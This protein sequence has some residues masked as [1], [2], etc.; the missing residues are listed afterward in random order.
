MSITIDLMNVLY[1]VIAYLVVGYFAMLAV[2]AYEIYHNLSRE[3]AKYK[4][5]LMV[6]ALY[7]AALF[8][9]AFPYAVFD[10]VRMA[11]SSRISSKLHDSVYKDSDG[12]EFDYKALCVKYANSIDVEFY[13]DDSP[14]FWA[15]GKH[16][17]VWKFAKSNFKIVSA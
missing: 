12:N 15:I 16:N 17:K 13:E 11:R 3:S 5:G 1:F 7:R 8:S 2:A 6:K 9:W 10:A 4:R 14:T